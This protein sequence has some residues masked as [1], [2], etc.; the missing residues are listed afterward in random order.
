MSDDPISVYRTELHNAALRRAS[1][2]QRRHKSAVA[3]G[4]A[5][6]AVI[7]VGS[8][9]A[10]PARWFNTSSTQLQIRG[11]QQELN[12]LNRGYVECM[13]GQGPHMAAPRAA[14]GAYQ[15]NA[16]ATLACRPFLEAI[17]ASCLT[18]R[19]GNERVLIV[20][21]SDERVT[22]ARA[23]ACVLAARRRAALAR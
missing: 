5:L 1:L 18:A 22:P 15:R 20:R 21:L 2:H 10:G 19:Q 8:A 17:V 16:T 9:I 13:A 11:R 14:G 12:Y 6:A 7:V 4:F 23:A 3:I